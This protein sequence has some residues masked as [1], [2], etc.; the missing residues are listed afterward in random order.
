MIN[1]KCIRH[2]NLKYHETFFYIYA[3]SI[4]QKENNRIAEDISA[5]IYNQKFKLNA[6]DICH[7]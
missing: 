3:N 6:D 2:C 5:A 7:V 1:I 4:A